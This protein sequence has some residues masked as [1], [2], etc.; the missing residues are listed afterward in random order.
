MPGFALRP[1]ARE[2]AKLPIGVAESDSLACV[3]R[4]AEPTCATVAGPYFSQPPP[5]ALFQACKVAVVDALDAAT[6]VMTSD[7]DPVE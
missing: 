3:V 1:K 7:A 6:T 4:P 2:S 5:G